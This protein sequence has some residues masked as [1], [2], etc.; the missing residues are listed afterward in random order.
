M[1]TIR[2]YQHGKLVHSVTGIAHQV[3]TEELREQYPEPYFQ[4][5]R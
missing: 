3:E 5:L 1:Q 4:W 2:I